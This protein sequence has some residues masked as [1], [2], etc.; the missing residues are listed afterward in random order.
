MRKDVTLILVFLLITYPLVVVAAHL[1]QSYVIFQSRGAF[2]DPPGHL[3]ITEVVLTTPDGERL[4][5]WWQQTPQARRTILYFQAN[6]TNI[7]FR[8]SRLDTF[9]RMG[10]NALLIDYRGYGKSSGRVT[11]EAD[12]YRDG[13][14]AWD[15]LIHQKRIPAEEI[16]VWGRSL[17]GG[18]ACEIAQGQAVAAL[19]LESTFYSMDEL[20]RRQYWFLPTTW[21]LKFHFENG[22]KLKHVSA[23]V[24]I[25]HSVEDDY[26]PYAQAGRLFDAAS[27]PRLLLQTTG[28]H[29]E[30][31]DSQV[32]VLGALQ[33]YLGL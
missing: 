12:I 4:H 11:R 33:R 18:V 13:R 21:L 26:I 22:R 6:G 29:L 7:S 27:E 25:I 9:Q 19:I 28:S 2:S 14:T 16:I 8:R 31:F 17:G 20:A 15:F 30:L 24:V 3:D 5:A 23:P 32:R 1:T 10:V